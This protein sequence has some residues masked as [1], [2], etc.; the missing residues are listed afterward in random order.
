MCVDYRQL[1]KRTTTDSYASPRI[2]DILD[3]LSGS[4]YFTVLDMC[5][6][7]TRLKYLK[8]MSVGQL[9]LWA[10]WDFGSLIAYLSA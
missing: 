1:N 9:L 7:I 2:E 4:K 6:G 10:H 5:Q 3:T 8:N